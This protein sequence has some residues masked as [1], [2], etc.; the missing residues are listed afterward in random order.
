MF[1]MIPA[2]PGWLA[3]IEFDTSDGTLHVPYRVEA[4]NPWGTAMVA[5]AE[6]GS[7]VSIEL[8]NGGKFIRLIPDEQAEQPARGVL[9]ARPW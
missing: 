9:A 7:L 1:T 8:I 3:V 4:W 5:D 2:A 6:T